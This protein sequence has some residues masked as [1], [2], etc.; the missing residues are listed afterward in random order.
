MKENKE[1]TNKWKDIGCSCIIRLNIVKMFILPKI[2]YRFNTIII[3]T[4]MA[5]FTEIENNPETQ[6]ELQ[7]TLSSQSNLEEEESSWHHNDFK[8]YYKAKVT[9]IVWY[10]H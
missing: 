2:I 9:E 3:K 6:M 1:D 10:R 8:I 7:K 4:P 5:F